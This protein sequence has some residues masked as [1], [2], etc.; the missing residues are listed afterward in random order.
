VR[1]AGLVA[2]ST[3]ASMRAFALVSGG[4]EGVAVAVTLAAEAVEGPCAV[5]L[6]A[7]GVASPSVRERVHKRSSHGVGV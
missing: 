2:P 7:V 3:A 1:V 6:R 5:P 4:V